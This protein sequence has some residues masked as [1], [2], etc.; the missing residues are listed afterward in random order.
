MS[1]H[2]SG[3][4]IGPDAHTS[5]TADGRRGRAHVP[6]DDA[7]VLLTRGL[8]AGYRGRRRRRVAVLED[9]DATLHRGQLVCLLGPNGAGKSTLLRTLVGA[10]SPLAGTVLLDGHDVNRM[11]PRERAQRLSAVFTDRIDAGFLSVRALVGLGRAPRLGWFSSMGGDDRDIVEWALDAAGANDLADRQVAELSDGEIQRVMIA[12]ALAQQPSLLVLD[13]P[14]AFLD[15]TRRVELMSL[16]DRLV[17]STALAVLMSTHD[18]DLALRVADRIWLVHPDGRFEMGA[19]EDLALRGS[20]AAAYAG[21]DIEFDHTAGTFV[22]ANPTIGPRI[23]ITGTEP[24]VTWARRAVTRAGWTPAPA[25]GAHRPVG[26]NGDPADQQAMISLEISYGGDRLRW[27]LTG[28]ASGPLDG[29][30]LATVVDHLRALA[31]TGPTIEL[32]TS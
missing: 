14:T 24:A 19:P 6:S 28:T 8:R 17:S 31:G 3:P 1:G 4:A 12:R 23:A 10:Q 32:S 15:L 25:E 5:S 7:P 27:R 29:D 22:V 13:E 21:G 11:S 2:L 30:D 26:R 18:L 16:L 9:V 20:V